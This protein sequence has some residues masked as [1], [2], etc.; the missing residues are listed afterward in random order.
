VTPPSCSVLSNY[1]ERRPVALPSALVARACSALAPVLPPPAVCPGAPSAS[2][3]A[4]PRPDAALPGRRRGLRRIGV[5]H[6][7]PGA[8]PPASLCGASVRRAV[9]H[10]AAPGLPSYSPWTGG[11][12]AQPCLSVWVRGDCRW[13]LVPGA[14]EHMCGKRSGGLHLLAC[15]HS[16]DVSGAVDVVQTLEGRATRQDLEEPDAKAAFVWI[17]GHYGESIQVRCMRPLPWRRRGAPRLRGSA[18]GR[19]RLRRPDTSGTCCS[20]RCAVRPGC[21]LDQPRC[22]GRSPPGSRGRARPARARHRTH[23]LGGACRRQDLR[24]DAAPTLP[25]I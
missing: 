14:D 8:R 17:L 10:S 4:G 2:A 24:S 20:Q 21:S 3:C 22:R 25:Y 18:L 13:P 16:D 23:T 12:R 15:L 7:A 19:G 6:L 5:R 11:R 1:C 9:A